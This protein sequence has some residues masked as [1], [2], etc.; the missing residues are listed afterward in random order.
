MNPEMQLLVSL[1]EHLG[2]HGQAL[3]QDAVKYVFQG[4]LGPGH[5]L[6][7]PDHV[8]KRVGQEM[9]GVKPDP[10]EPLTED[11]GPV[12]MRLN[13]RRAKAE[14]I[15]PAWITEMMMH[16]PQ[17]G[18]TRQD[19]M[20]FIRRHM[21]TIRAEGL[22]EAAARLEEEGYLPSHTEAYRG[23]YAP[24][25]RVVSRSF[26]CLMPLLC[27]LG[28]QDGAGRRIIS[29]DGRCASGKTTMAESLSLVLRAPV[30]H[31]DEFVVPHA[32]KTPERLRIPGGNCD[33][34]RLQAEVLEP[35]HT[36][37]R[38][39]VNRYDCHGDCMLPPETIQET[40][41]LILEGSYAN[42]PALRELADVRVFVRT[43]EE[44]RMARLKKRE[45]AA[46]FRRFQEMWIPLEE[47][48][49]TYYKL[50]DDGCLVI[51]GDGAGQ[52]EN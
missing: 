3:G 24:A 7:D 2:T 12:W 34:E 37:G 29:M 51:D 48:Y 9:D 13:L 35:F 19:V 5:L 8:M 36:Q 21:D 46:S 44:T 38:C 39:V 17:P 42:M 47:A 10:Q 15:S 41:Y 25:Y 20:D 43:S 1:E 49:F 26:Q 22:Q 11:L 4:M 6:T 14:G 52:Q 16:G 30:V 45:S 28:K 40:P 50:P 23:A 27:V 31:T 32:R 33:W 18:Y